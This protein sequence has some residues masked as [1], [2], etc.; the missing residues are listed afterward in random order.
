MTPYP[1]IEAILQPSKR[2]IVLLH[3][4]GSDG[5]DLIDIAKLMQH[6]LPDYHYISPH[7]IE[8][9]DMAPFG[10]QWFSLSNRDPAVIMSLIPNNVKLLQT[11]IKNKQ[12]ELNITNEQTIILGFSQGAMIGLYLTLI[13]D[14]PFAGMIGFSG[15]LIPPKQ[16]INT[17]TPI[18]LIHGESDD[19][20]DVGSV[21]EITQYLDTYNIKYYTLTI[22]GLGHSIDGQGIDYAIKFIKKHQKDCIM[23]K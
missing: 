18:C 20:V 15:R 6:E 23:N 14:V 22:Q 9:Y 19:V 17:N 13:Q 16:C 10:R 12:S 11:M 2:L 4:V 5:Y 7:G 1:E 8:S 3:G 21:S